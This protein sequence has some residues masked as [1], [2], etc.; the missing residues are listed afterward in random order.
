M[1][2]ELLFWLFAIAL[3]TGLISRKLKLSR[4]Y[5]RAPREKNSWQKLDHGIDPSVDE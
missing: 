1:N 2:A 4:R 3:L 5:E